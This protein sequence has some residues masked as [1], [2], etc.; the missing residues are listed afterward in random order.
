MVELFTSVINIS[1]NQ[2]TSPEIGMYERRGRQGEIAELT[3]S[4]QDAESSSFTDSRSKD[5]EADPLHAASICA[6]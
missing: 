1:D 5:G 6:N 4:G 2:R 3:E